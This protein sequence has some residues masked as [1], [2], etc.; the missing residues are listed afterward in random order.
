[1]GHWAAGLPPQAQI[2]GAHVCVRRDSGAADRRAGGGGAVRVEL[3]RHAGDEGLGGGQDG[4]SNGSGVHAEDLD[5]GELELVGAG[6]LDTEIAT[7]GVGKESARGLRNGGL[8]GAPGGGSGLQR[9][10]CV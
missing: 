1:M 2:A 9:S 6:Q 3:L 4:D 8:V 5:F 10:G 7:D